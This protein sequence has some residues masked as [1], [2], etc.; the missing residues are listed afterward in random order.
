MAT[1]A[2]PVDPS[3]NVGWGASGSG[4]GRGGTVVV[5]GIG[6]VVVVGA[7]VAAVVRT[8]VVPAEAAVAVE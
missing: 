1:T 4:C 7:V 6:N 5:V 8:E 2:T 3:G